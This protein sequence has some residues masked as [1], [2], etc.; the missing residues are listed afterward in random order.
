[1][2]QV[3][4]RLRLMA[5]L[6]VLASLSAH[7]SCSTLPPPAP[8]EPPEI[9]PPVARS[10]LDEPTPV[11]DGVGPPDHWIE[12]YGAY[13]NAAQREAY[14]RTPPQH[15]MDRWGTLILDI[16]LREDLLQQSQEEG[17]LS[18]DDVEKYRRLP[19]ANA[20]RAFVQERRRKAQERAVPDSTADGTRKPL[21]KEN[22]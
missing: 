7:A 13:F 16:R 10:D 18:R 11:A 9:V 17:I 22:E 12:A 19:D 21:K 5:R 2:T 1:M 3:C 14:L 6:F 4:R 8:H 20:A 15:R